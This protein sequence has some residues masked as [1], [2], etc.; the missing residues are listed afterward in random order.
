MVH[1]E[2]HAGGTT[3]TLHPNRSAS[4]TEIR[5]FL[6]LICGTTLAVG[7]FWALIGLWAVLPFSGIEAAL[8]FYF[9]YRVS[10]ASYQ[11]Q[12]IT[13]AA[14]H[15]LIQFGNY[16]PKRSWRL[17]KQHAYLALLEP[18]HG[19]DLPGLSI[20]DYQQRIQ[21]GTFL[22]RDDK[23]LA[24]EA[25]KRAGLFVRSHDKVADSLF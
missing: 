17:D 15:V 18:E 1:S 9:L 2:T 14:D 16:F 13:V 8:V 23:T 22:S 21:L 12:Q 24:L 20:F 5:L 3:I 6:L 4:W 10:H 19:N 11:Q 7:A 25:L